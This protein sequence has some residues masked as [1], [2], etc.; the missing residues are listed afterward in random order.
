MKK[1]IVAALCGLSLTAPVIADS[2]SSYAKTRSYEVTV[3]NIT[4]GQSF[5]P[6]LT[7]A[8]KSSI[9]FFEL[10]EEASPELATLAES[11]NPAPLKGVL[12]SATNLVNGTN[13]TEGLLLPGASITFTL[14]SS[15]GFQRFSLAAMLIPTNDTFVSLDSVR[16]PFRGKVEYL[17]NAYDAGSETNTE[18]CAD[19]PGPACG[20]AGPSPEDDGEGYVYTSPGINGEAELSS[21]A[22][23]WK[24]SVAKVTIRR[25]N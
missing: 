18:V 20:G 16:L 1:S 6:I 24:N 22:Y 13:A 3:T 23:D 21:S 17:A 12:D 11:G 5:T 7:A 4:K 10:G 8:H 2:Y 14:D 9:S 15:F 25:I 19:I